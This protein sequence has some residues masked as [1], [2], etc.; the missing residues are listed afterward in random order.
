[1]LNVSPK[2]DGSIPDDQQKVLLAIGEW[3]QTNGEAIYDSRAW[4]IPG[5]GPGTPTECPP[6]WK[7]GSTAD[8]TNA[9]KDGPAP[10]VQITEAGF[11]FTTAGANLYAFG[12]RYPVAAGRGNVATAT[13]KSLSTSAAKVERV[14]LL[15][16]SSP[17]LAFKQTSDALIVTLPPTAPIPNM[18]Y[19]LRIEGMQ[20][21]G[22]G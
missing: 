12:Y 16:P 22:L 8:Q 1:M 18:P 5:E 10:R 6:D 14:T 2:G 19:A 3:L 4:R 20:G 7:G 11:R 9:I 15:G 13:I 17:P 21:L